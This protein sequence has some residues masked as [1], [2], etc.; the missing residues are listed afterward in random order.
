MCSLTIHDKR[1][2]ANKLLLL[3]QEPGLTP[4]RLALLLTS[5]TTLS[6][7]HTSSAAPPR[8]IWLHDPS[9][10]IDPLTE[11]EGVE[12]WGKATVG[13]EGDVEV[14]EEGV[15]LDATEVE[16]KADGMEV[17]EE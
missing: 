16:A 17:D 10:A 7:L 8:S 14:G 5:L 15:K 2:I 6:T 3:F 11:E 13:G 1:T 4:P 12:E 9:T